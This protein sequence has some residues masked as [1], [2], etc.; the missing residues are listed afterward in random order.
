LDVNGTGTDFSTFATYPRVDGP[1]SAPTTGQQLVVKQY[2]D[3]TAGAYLPLAGGTMAGSINMGGQTITN[4]G[5]ITT[6][7][8]VASA[9]SL[10]NATAGGTAGI[11]AL[12]TDTLGV[13]SNNMYITQT[14]GALSLFKP[15]AN[16]V[17][18]YSA[19]ASTNLF[20]YLVPQFYGE[21]HIFTGSAVAPV[22]NYN[23]NATYTVLG[24]SISLNPFYCEITNGA[25]ASLIVKVRYP[26]GGIP[27]A[28]YPPVST[29][30]TTVAPSGTWADQTILPV[31]LVGT[32]T[33]SIA[34]G[35]TKRLFFNGTNWYLI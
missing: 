19:G 35:A 6:A 16:P 23:T 21:R 30:P 25:T 33:P 7:G 24:N 27:P 3:N 20:T 31:G 28:Q 10:P 18:I 26:S 15:L 14:S 8:V 34:S 13:A 2:V 12:Q 32:T 9:L 4:A 5:T 29:A 1:Y 11:T 17:I 22:L